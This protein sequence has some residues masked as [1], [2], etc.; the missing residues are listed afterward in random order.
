MHQTIVTCGNADASLAHVLTHAI[1]T[2][3][4]PRHQI[5]R[6]MGM[7]R[8]TLLRVMRGDRTVSLDEAA[9]VFELCGACPRASLILMPV[10]FVV[11]FCIF[12]LF[13]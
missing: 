13:F 1:E 12:L 5:A 4:K 6:E 7:H 10:L 3:D 8:E 2:S 11:C 9:R